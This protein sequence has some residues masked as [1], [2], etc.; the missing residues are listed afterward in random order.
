[1]IHRLQTIQSALHDDETP[2]Y[3]RVEFHTDTT[4][5]EFKIHAVSGEVLSREEMPYALQ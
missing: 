2:P 4:R 3:W 5:F 1:M